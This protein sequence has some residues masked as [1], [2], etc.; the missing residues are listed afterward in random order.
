MFSGIV[1]CVGR[2]ARRTEAGGDVRLAIDAAGAPFGSIERGGS[3]AVNGCCLTAAAVLGNGFEADVSR[4]TLTMTTFAALEEGAR[5]NLEPSLKLGDPLDG[6]W[7]SG[8]IDGVGRVL[9]VGRAAR[10]TVLT[11]E[12]PEALARYV[13]RKGSVAVDGV[14]LTVNAVEGRRFEVNVV[15]HTLAATIIG[16]YRA[17]TAVNIEVDIV[18]RYLERLLVER[19]P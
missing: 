12:L 4:E 14:S 10:S 5:V 7:V 11:L 15:P 6:H 3:I 18:A 1:R 8:H 16:E 19:L 2:I 17:G 13:A 9:E